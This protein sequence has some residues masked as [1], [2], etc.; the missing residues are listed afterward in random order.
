MTENAFYAADRR[1]WVDRF[2]SRLGFGRAHAERPEDLEGFAP[3]YMI[4]GVVAKLDWL[5]RCR[6]FISGKISV[7]IATKTD[8]VVGKMDSVSSL[9]VLPPNF[10]IKAN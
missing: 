9:T 5:D 10:L 2:W 8:V 4:T 1:S 6:A 3:S 7:E